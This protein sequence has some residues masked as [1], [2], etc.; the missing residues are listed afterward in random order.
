M[1][2][3]DIIVAM[4]EGIVAKLVTTFLKNGDTINRDTIPLKV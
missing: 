4:A 3:A 1:L 2:D